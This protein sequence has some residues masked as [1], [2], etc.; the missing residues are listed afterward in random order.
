MRK[1]ELRRPV[2]ASADI[3][4]QVITDLEGAPDI[5]S[6]IDR[7]EMLA[8]AGSFGIGTRW[9]ETRTMFGR[10]ATEEMQITGVDEGQ[11][12]TVESHAAGADYRWTLSVFP[13]GERAS[14]LAIVF[15]AEPRT[16]A[17]KVLASTVGRLFERSTRKAVRRDLDDMAAE[18]ERRASSPEL[19]GRGPGGT[20]SP[21]QDR[22]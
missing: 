19:D 17:A 18:A 5:V 3:L 6:G 21:R 9:R 13:E 11:S 14:Q 12:Y 20:E 15:G 4:W 2:G 16:A 1:I 10:S 8:G 22:A 7:I